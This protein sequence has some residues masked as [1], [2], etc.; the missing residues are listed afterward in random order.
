MPNTFILE[1]AFEYSLSAISHDVA[2]GTIWIDYIE[3]VKQMP[4]MTSYEESV[5]MQTLRKL[6]QRAVISN[7]TKVDFERIWRDYDMFENAIHKELVW[8][9]VSVLT[10]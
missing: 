8:S 9:F 4:A 10:Y 3:F 7:L 2:S 5:R 6:Y 1:A